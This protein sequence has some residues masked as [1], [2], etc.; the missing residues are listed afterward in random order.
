V[1]SDKSRSVSFADRTKSG[2]IEQTLFPQIE[3]SET[4]STNPPEPRIKLKA[5]TEM[6][7]LGYKTMSMKLTEASEVLD[8]RIDQFIELVKQY[9]KLDDSAF[10]NAAAQSTSEIVAVGRI[11]SDTAE[12]RLNAASAVLETSRR[13]GAGLRVP[14]NF[15]AVAAYELFPGKIIALRG[16][17]AS[18]DYFSVTEI[19]PMPLLIEAASKPSELDISNARLATENEDA[20]ED[21]TRPLNILV[22]SGP[23]TTDNDLDFAALQQFL[24][25]AQDSKADALLLF[26]PFIDAEHPLIRTGDYDPPPSAPNATVPTL[27]DLFRHHISTVLTSFANSVPTCSIVLIP[28]LRDAVSRHMAWPQDRLL[29]REL[30][31]P[32]QAQCVTNPMMLSLNEVV[33]G[34]SNIDL[35]DMLRREECIGGKAKT[36]NP[37]ERGPRAIIEQ[38]HFF[39]VFPPTS[40]ENLR[41]P[42]GI[43]E[44][45]DEQT[46]GTSDVRAPF[47]PLGASIDTA[48]LKL[49]EL[50][51]VRPDVLITP[52]VLTPFARVSHAVE[53]YF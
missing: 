42:T 11:A 2:E 24:S 21:V 10:G 28:S 20:I 18:G 8:D 14:L 52:S 25:V 53:L 16:T 44:N 38:R 17:N 15:D 5:N 4:T 19:L 30:G 45:V 22:G 39:P 29:K 6:S 34:M 41:Q 48:Y 37:L 26:G 32:R 51:L 36:T 40:R 27:A 35:P 7:K 23:Y 31:L 50:I 9:H 43:E 3:V 33:V 49:G 1:R 47:L 13:T 12:G 46:K